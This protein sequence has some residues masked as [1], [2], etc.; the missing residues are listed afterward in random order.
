MSYNLDCS[1]LILGRVYAV[2][3]PH[4]SP[5]SV[6]SQLV[7]STQFLNLLSFYSF[8]RYTTNR[9]SYLVILI[10][11]FDNSFVSAT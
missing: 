10:L 3:Q 11:Y 8:E 4:R 9:W 5:I 2:P 1:A 7:E 6:V